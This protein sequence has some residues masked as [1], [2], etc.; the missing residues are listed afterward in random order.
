MVCGTVGVAGLGLI[1]SSVA[2]GLAA[3]FARS[4]IG[5]DPDRS[6]RA[7]AATY[8]TSTCS[9]LD[10]LHGAD[11][12]VLAA[13]PGQIPDLIRQIASWKDEKTVV[14]DVASV[15]MHVVDA[16]PKDLRARFVP[17]HPMAGRD[18]AGPHEARPDL[19]KD[20]KWIICPFKETEESAVQLVRA[21][22]K[23][24]RAHLVVMTPKDHDRHVAL[25]SH[26]PHVLASA[27]LIE[28]ASL[29]Q[30]EISGPS[31]SDVT[32]VGGSNPALWADILLANK[33]SVLEAIKAHDKTMEEFTKAL[34]KGD[35]TM[36]E[37]LITQAKESK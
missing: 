22:A 32:R 28:S 2:Q 26:L 3:G 24:F 14:T 27:L 1:G 8:V 15:K 11:L 16:V 33:K 25:L 9:R 17:G 37:A 35:A 12:I 34:E 29:E 18:S 21:M 20:A 23:H 6:A 10:D 31:W 13:P 5:F 30:R 19:F 36:L 4:V 7:N